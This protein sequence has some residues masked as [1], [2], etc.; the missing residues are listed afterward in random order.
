LKKLTA[1]ESS[2]SGA[3]RGSPPQGNR[4]LWKIASQSCSSREFNLHSDLGIHR[5]P[6][7]GLSPLQL[8]DSSRNLFWGGGPKRQARGRRLCEK[9][10]GLQKKFVAITSKKKKK[11][12]QIKSSRRREFWDEGT[13]MNA[14]GLKKISDLSTDIRMFFQ[15]LPRETRYLR[16]Q[17]K[18]VVLRRRGG[19]KGLLAEGRKRSSATVIEE[20]KKN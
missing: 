1:S 13:G 2:R 14:I 8:E 3:K 12:L 18:R 7:Q 17:E 5:F 10:R 19:G 20:E 9:K 4:R 11:D 15:Q 16:R 6:G